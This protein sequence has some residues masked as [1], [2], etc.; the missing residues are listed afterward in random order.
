MIHMEGCNLIPQMQAF[1]SG[2]FMIP[3]SEVSYFSTNDLPA[4]CSM[5]QMHVCKCL[6]LSQIK[7]LSTYLQRSFGD[8]KHGD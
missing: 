6:D 7:G 8:V 2:F 3:L 5:R 1:M 4:V